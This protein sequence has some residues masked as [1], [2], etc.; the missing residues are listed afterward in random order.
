MKASNL[1]WLPKNVQAESSTEFVKNYVMKPFEKGQITIT[2]LGSRMLK[3]IIRLF[4]DLADTYELQK[5]GF[6]PIQP[7]SFW[8]ESGRN[9]EFGSSVFK[10]GEEHILS[11]SD[12]ELLVNLL[13]MR[14]NIPYTKDLMVYDIGYRFREGEIRQPFTIQAFLGLP[15]YTIN[16][17]GS[18]DCVLNNIYRL[19][20]DFFKALGL[21]SIVEPKLENPR[22]MDFIYPFEIGSDKSNYCEPCS[23]HLWY[24]IHQCDC[25]NSSLKSIRGL[26]LGVISDKTDLLKNMNIAHNDDMRLN[27]C[28]LGLNRL[29]FA[30][31]DNSLRKNENLNGAIS[32]YTNVIICD[33]QGYQDAL[34]YYDKNRLETLLDDR[35]IST[36]SKI[37][38][39]KFMGTPSLWGFING[40]QGP[41]T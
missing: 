17:S 6:P 30:S 39:W 40:Q 5:V 32:P 23:K 15:I 8:K 9:S 20:R 14:G 16:S 33:K 11:A 7:V 28:G 1:L 12:E 37:E 38:F 34:Q 36:A 18:Q 13:K 29:L 10:I 35:K 19:Y 2:P 21:D 27:S 3:K 25:G 41:I 22:Y 4:E 24:S 26:S 31:I